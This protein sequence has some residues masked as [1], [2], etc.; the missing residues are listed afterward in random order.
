M[1]DIFILIASVLCVLLGLLMVLI[2]TKIMKKEK[3]ELVGEV[4]LFR[5][6]GIFV[7]VCAIAIIINICQ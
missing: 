6:K 5:K 7:I 4:S 2:P 3:I 1:L